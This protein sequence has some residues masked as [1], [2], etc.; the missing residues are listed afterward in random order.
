VRLHV[1]TDPL[2]V[3][4]SAQLLE[5]V[6]AGHCFIGFDLF[7]DTSG[8]RFEAQTPT[9]TKF[10][11][12]EVP[13]QNDLRLHIQT[14]VPTRMVLFK[15]GSVILN[16]SRSASEDFPVK[17]RGVYRVEAYLPEVERIVGEKP[18]IISN[19]IYIR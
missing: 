11:G 4:D 3:F 2:K 1:F 15:D 9:E 17:E 12:D 13:L 14:P 8:F 5:A 7:G 16:E 18:W 19:P 6:K 10:Q